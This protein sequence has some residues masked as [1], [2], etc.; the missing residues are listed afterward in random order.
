MALHTIQNSAEQKGEPVFLHFEKPD[1]PD[2]KP[3][4]KNIS[5]NDIMKNIGAPQFDY[6]TFKSA[7]DADSSIEQYVD[8]FNADGIEI[9]T[10]D[11]DID[12]PQQQRDDK[13]SVSSMAKAATDLSDN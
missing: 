12:K 6:D 2:L 7:Y 5:F 13:N 11:S 10:D 8:N 1:L 3:G 4:F 9:N